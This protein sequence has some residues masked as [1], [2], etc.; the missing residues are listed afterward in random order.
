MLYFQ[1]F[2]RFLGTY[3]FPARLQGLQSECGKFSTYW[4]NCSHSW[5]I[6]LSLSIVILPPLRCTLSLYTLKIKFSN[7]SHVVD[8]SEK[9]IFSDIYWLKIVY[10]HLFRFY[11]KVSF[12]S[13]SNFFKLC[14]SGVHP[15]SRCFFFLGRVRVFFHWISI[16][17]WWWIHYLLKNYYLPWKTLDFDALL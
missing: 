3:H 9:V 16:T 5:K 1:G 11:L 15:L 8:Q 6:Q 10:F 4:M 13:Q 12:F 14:P 2:P 7:F 17:K